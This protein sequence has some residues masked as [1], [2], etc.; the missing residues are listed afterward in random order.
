MS[1]VAR[2]CSVGLLLVDIY[3]DKKIMYPGG[4]ELNVAVY[5]SR[6]GNESGIIGVF[7]S[8]PSSGFLQT[9]LQAE[10]VDYSHSRYAEGPCAN[11]T[12]K[13]VNGDRVF[14]GHNNGG[15][16]GMFPIEI[17][18]EDEPYITSF[19][20]VSTSTYGRM[21]PQQ[22]QKLCSLGIP[23]AYDFSHDAPQEMV[24]QLLPCVTYAFF[25][26]ADKSDVEIKRFI[27]AC[28][29]KGGH[30][31]IC[32]AGERG[33]FALVDGAM[34][35]QEAEKANVIDTMG[36][37][38]SFIAAFLTTI[39]DPQKDRD[40]RAALKAAAVFAAETCTKEGAVGHPAPIA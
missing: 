34:Y 25:S 35:R 36:A 5:A 11:S 24:D 31:I 18:A 12:V 7:G 1:A 37:G 32:T 17:T 10:H 21:H 6:L 23:V 14:T 22:V 19:D 28:A 20:V 29:E 40:V 30:N 4:N 8:D 9:V 26:A 39:E 15:V 27:Y 3:T 38:D 2:L 16:T 33:A 13:I